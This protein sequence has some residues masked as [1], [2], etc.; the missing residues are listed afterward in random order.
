MNDRLFPLRRHWILRP[1]AVLV[2]SSFGLALSA[3]PARAA[4]DGTLTLVVGYPAGGT[5]DQVARILAP[6]LS[7]RLRMT[8]KVENHVGDSGHQ[9][10]RH[11]AKADAGQNILLLSNPATM[12]IAPVTQDNLGYS[13]DKDFTPVSHVVDYELALAI[14]KDLPP[15]RMMFLVSWLW[16]HPEDSR[17]AVPALASLPHFFGLKLG[18]AARVKPAIIDGKGSANLAANLANG[19]E[20][21]AID[22]LGALLPRHQKGEVIILATS[23]R[24][25]SRQLPDVPTFHENGL[26][27]NALGWNVF[28]APSAMPAAKVQALGGHIR[29]VMSDPA[30]R[31]AILNTGMTPVAAGPDE[32]A[33]MLRQFRSEWEP[34][35]RHYSFAP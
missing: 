14:N 34:L 18:H 33:H 28:Y 3:Q 19:R 31:K 23:G 30:V 25:R 4:S 27:L 13:P 8:V 11:V 24:Q 22:T 16:S 5:S 10:A 35:V 32:T 20:K 7:A 26:K 6:H 12:V 17:F 15:N 9:A 2:G 29:A 21:I 1:L